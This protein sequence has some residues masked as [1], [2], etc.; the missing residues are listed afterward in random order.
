MPAL[1]AAPAKQADAGLDRLLGAVLRARSAMVDE[2]RSRPTD[3][4]RQAD[5]RKALLAS[6]ESYTTALASRGLAPPPR[7]RDELALQRRLAGN[8]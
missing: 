7:L 6:L 2:L 1:A 4:K 3:A 8:R 5:A